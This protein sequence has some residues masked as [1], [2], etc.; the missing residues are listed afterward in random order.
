MKP[1]KFEYHAPST[2]DE[3][4]ALLAQYRGD[5]KVLAGGQSLLPVLNFRLAAPAALIDINRIQ[6]LAYIR[7]DGN[8]ILIGAATRQRTIENDALVAA[9]LPLLREAT[10]WVAHLPIRT[11]GTIGGSLSH[12]DPAAEYPMIALALDARMVIRG[13]GGTRIVPA[14]EFFLSYLTTAL[15]PTE[16]LSEIRVPAMP[17]TAGSAVEE[18]AR[19]KGDF[20]IVAIAASV[21]RDRDRCTYVRLAAAGVGPTPIRLHAAEAILLEHG[22]GTEAMSAAAASAARAVQPLDDLHASAEYRRHLTKV[23][24]GRALARALAATDPRG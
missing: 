23:L 14:Q 19:R 17:S 15:E 24:V 22:V 9:K 1:P 12:A 20:A 11:R 6:E 21:A 4:V 2:L 5:A 16:I 18:F 10:G 7:E 8:E 3:A 13:S